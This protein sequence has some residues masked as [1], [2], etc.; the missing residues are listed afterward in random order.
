MNDP[1]SGKSLTARNTGMV[2]APSVRSSLDGG[3]TPPGSTNQKPM[4]R[5]N[6]E[7]ELLDDLMAPARKWEVFDAR[8][9]TPLKKTVKKKKGLP[10]G[11]PRHGT[12]NGYNN[13]GCRCPPCKKAWSEDRL[14]RR[15]AKGVLPA[16]LYQAEQGERHNANRYSKGKC[17]CPVCTA[18]ASARRKEAR[19][20]AAARQVDVARRMLRDN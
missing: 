18:A 1:A 2:V 4:K 17:R 20:R 5:Y 6:S 15:R 8:T 13:H 9:G 12:A 10:P 3:S 7:Q 14:A 19:R 16:E 11:D